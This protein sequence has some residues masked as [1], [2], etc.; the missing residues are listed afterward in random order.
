MNEENWVSTPIFENFIA[1]DYLREIRQS[2]GCVEQQVIRV[3]SVE[4]IKPLWNESMALEVDLCLNGPLRVEFDQVVNQ[5]DDWQFT[6]SD[7]FVDIER[8]LDIEGSYSQSIDTQCES[9]FY[10]FRIANSQIDDESIVYV[11]N[12]FSPN[13][14]G[15]NDVFYCSSPHEVE[16]FEIQVYDR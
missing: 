11:P 6:W 4:F 3:G 10:E 15:V 7:G 16:S 12:T 8:R 14:D 1:D 13:G 2:D 5:M 9:K